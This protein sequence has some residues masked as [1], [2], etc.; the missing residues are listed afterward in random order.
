MDD[1]KKCVK[2][3]LM[4]ETDRHN[5]KYEIN[6]LFVNGFDNFFQEKTFRQCF[7]LRF[8]DCDLFLKK[9]FYD[10]V[11]SV[12]YNNLIKLLR[13]NLNHP[14]FAGVNVYIHDL[15]VQMHYSDITD[16]NPY[17]LVIAIVSEFAYDERIT[18]F[19]VKS[20][21][22]LLQSHNLIDTFRQPKQCLFDLM[23]NNIDIYEED[24]FC[25][26][27]LQ[28]LFEKLVYLVDDDIQ[29]DNNKRQRTD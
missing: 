22:Y 19:S 17:Y 11:K 5:N 20:R 23:Y 10:S 29:T 9:E 18:Q 27:K 1:I 3:L 26:D 14:T 2:E 28:T 7:T 4:K 8:R 6:S 16:Q 12:F 13:H 15:D 24:Y 21:E 25:F